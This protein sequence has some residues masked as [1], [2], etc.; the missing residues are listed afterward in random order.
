MRLLRRETAAHQAHR[1][2]TETKV[3]PEGTDLLE[4]LAQWDPPEFRDLMES[5]VNEEMTVA[6]DPE[7]IAVSVAQLVRLAVQDPPE[8]TD[9]TEPPVLL[10]S[11]E[12]LDLLVNL[13]S[14]VWAEL[15]V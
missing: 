11:A 4:L 12:P 9:V 10:E 6:P 14:L 8:L 5:L 15:L 2:P 1:V 13:D 7:E 3:P